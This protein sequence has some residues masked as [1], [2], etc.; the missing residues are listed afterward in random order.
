VGRNTYDQTAGSI[1]VLVKDVV[2]SWVYIRAISG[3]QDGLQV[4]GQFGAMSN[5]TFFLGQIY[6]NKI[7]VHLTAAGSGWCNDNSFF[8]GFLTHSSS[9][10]TTVAGYHLV[11]DDFATS[12]LNNNRWF[13]P[14]FEAGKP[15]IIAASIGGQYNLI[16]QP[17]LENSALPATITGSVTTGGVMSV[18]GTAAYLLPGMYVSGTGIPAGAAIGSQLTGATGSTGTYQL[19]INPGS[20]VSSETITIN[21]VIGFTSSSIRCG[22]VGAGY[23]VA[24]SNVVD[25]GLGNYWQAQEGLHLAGGGGPVL[26]LQSTS[27]GSVHLLSVRNPSGTEQG[28]IDGTGTA[29]LNGAYINSGLRWSTSSGTYTDRG[30]FVGSYTTPNG[31]VTAQNGSLYLCTTGGNTNTGW[32]AK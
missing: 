2:Y 13:G 22:L 32:V 15:G 19:T 31:N 6:D 16:Y 3:F 21:Y 30:L 20:A 8:G 5:V 27:S 10:P 9:Y 25:L 24:N 1:G 11:V 26:S 28:Y 18:S 17:R 29:N 12:P 23:G 4:K 7:N 14:D